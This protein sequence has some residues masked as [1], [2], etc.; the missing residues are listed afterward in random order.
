MPRKT[1]VAASKTR[2]RTN[3]PSCNE[4]TLDLGLSGLKIRTKASQQSVIVTANRARDLIDT[5]LWIAHIVSLGLLLVVF[6][7]TTFH[8][9][10][11]LSKDLWEASFA[12]CVAGRAYCLFRTKAH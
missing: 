8:D 1:T 11:G 6:P 4:F 3:Q 9:F 2:P 7:T 10:A 12:L 5:E